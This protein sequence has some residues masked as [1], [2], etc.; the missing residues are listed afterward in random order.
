MDFTPEQERRLSLLGTSVVI[1]A[2]VEAI[3]GE[4]GADGAIPDPE[5]VVSEVTKR[6]ENI[7][8]GDALSGEEE[9]DILLREYRQISEQSSEANERDGMGTQRR[10]TVIKKDAEGRPYEAMM[11]VVSS[12]LSVASSLEYDA[13]EVI[14]NGMSECPFCGG[15]D[16]QV[17]SISEFYCNSC[18][19]AWHGQSDTA[20]EEIFAEVLGKTDDLEQLFKEHNERLEERRQNGMIVKR[21][22]KDSGDQDD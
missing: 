19:E 3:S 18:D 2:M 15:A 22:V 13:G 7:K 12:N 9:T 6:L 5:E 16:I 21:V 8:V 17:V 14:A 1:D 11:D 4:M 10:I 20:M